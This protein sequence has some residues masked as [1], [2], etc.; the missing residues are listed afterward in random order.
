MLA[1]RA[2]AGSVAHS[3]SG[4]VPKSTLE[5]CWWCGSSWWR[6]CPCKCQDP[7]Q[8][9]PVTPKHHWQEQIGWDQVLT[10]RWGTPED[11]D[12]AIF[13]C[14]RFAFIHAE[15]SPMHYDPLSKTA[16]VG[17]LTTSINV[18]VVCNAYACGVRWWRLTSC[19]R[20]AVYRRN[21][22]S[23]RIEPCGTV[24]LFKSTWIQINPFTLLVP[25]DRPCRPP[26]VRSARNPRLYISAHTKLSSKCPV[27]LRTVIDV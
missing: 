18:G 8:R 26:A 16:S 13:S 11:L 4:T 20:L 23:P 24:G 3:E 17:W 9:W 19:N 12:L 27:Q 5:W 25:V 1:V 14:S 15:I 10:S 21:K 2:V 22:I 6:Q 7:A